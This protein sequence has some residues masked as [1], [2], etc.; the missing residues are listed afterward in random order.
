[1]LPLKNIKSSHLIFSKIDLLKLITNNNKK[2]YDGAKKCLIKN[3]H[4][5]FC[6][7]QFLCPK[8]V[9][10]KTRILIGEKKDGCYVMLDDFE[11]IKIA[12]SIGI[13]YKIHFDKTLAD[14]GID[15][16]MY[17]HT[18][19][20]LPYENIRFHWKKIGLGGKSSILNNIQT[21]HDMI[22]ENGHTEEKN[23]I[24]KIDIEGAEWNSLDKVSE[25]VLKQFKYIL[26]EYHFFRINLPLFF[27]VLR[28][29]HKTHQVFYV[30]C[31]PFVGIS[32]FGNNRICSAIEVSY[33][34]RTGYEFVKDKSIYPI[35]KFS[36]GSK[37]GFNIN[38]LKLFDY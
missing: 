33:I 26:I 7:Y 35:Q 28:K 5:E 18:I 29:M 19:D 24:L 21:L 32:T 38:I 23:M 25:D 4:E 22:K 3:S 15:I 36:Y 9:K 1:M 14:K 11:N 27:K 12:Y 6:L 31:C 37:E 10:G 34:I 20:K 13:S 2:L 16:Y 30:H 17:D 8:E